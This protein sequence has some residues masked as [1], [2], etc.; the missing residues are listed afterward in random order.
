MPLGQTP[1]VMSGV[2]MWKTEAMQRALSIDQSLNV[3]V[4]NDFETNTD[5][6]S[7][8][9]LSGTVT[10]DTGLTGGVAR[11]KSGAISLATAIVYNA[12]GSALIGQPLNESWYVQSRCWIKNAPVHYG[13]ACVGIQDTTGAGPQYVTFGFIGDYDPTYLVLLMSIADGSIIQVTTNVPADT[14]QFHDYGIGRD[15]VNDKLYA[16]YDGTPALELDGPF[17]KL[18]SNPCFEF[19]GI[20]NPNISAENIELWIDNIAAVVKQV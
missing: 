12:G 14:S 2:S 1:F 6:S 11:I 8:T 16:L 10:Y 5:S 4:A 9:T 20:I 7:A 3:I 18:T 15:V 17:P 13:F 19:A